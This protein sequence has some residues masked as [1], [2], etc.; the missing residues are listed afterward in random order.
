MTLLHLVFLHGNCPEPPPSL[1]TNSVQ[2]LKALGLEDLPVINVQYPNLGTTVDKT[3]RGQ[4]GL[5]VNGIKKRPEGEKSYRVRYQKLGKEWT[6]LNDDRVLSTL[7]LHT[8]SHR[9]MC[10]VVQKEDKKNGRSPLMP[11]LGNGE[12]VSKTTID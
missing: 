3:V 8:H 4:S 7:F 5:V 11:V 12:K 10:G 2:E 6:R 1:S 9:N